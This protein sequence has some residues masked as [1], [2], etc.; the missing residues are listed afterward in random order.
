[1]AEIVHTFR[2][3][4]N[5]DSLNQWLSGLV[6]REKLCQKRWAGFKARPPRRRIRSSSGGSYWLLALPARQQFSQA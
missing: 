6:F 5:P 3:N 2:Q 1:V 4:E